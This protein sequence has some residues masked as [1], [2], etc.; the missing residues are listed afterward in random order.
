MAKKKKK[1]KYVKVCPKCKSPN[2]RMDKS[3]LQ[4]IGALPT[5]YICGKCEHSGYNFPEVPISELKGFEEEVDKEHLRDVKKDKTPLLDT[6]YG[7]FEVRFWWKIVAPVFLLLGIFL[8][9]KDPIYG[10]ILTVLG[11]FMFYITYFKKRKL[12]E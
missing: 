7:K 6:S 11:L 5:V 12:K 9:F 1:E 4:Q 10:I 3:T 8:L 2:V